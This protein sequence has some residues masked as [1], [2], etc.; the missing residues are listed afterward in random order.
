MKNLLIVLAMLMSTSA[1][2]QSYY[3]YGGNYGDKSYETPKR[4][5]SIGRIDESYINGNSSIARESGRLDRSLE[6]QENRQ[7]YNLINGRNYND[8][9][10]DGRRYR[11]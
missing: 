5:S 7:M 10:Y 9:G 11:Y 4:S 3:D 1:L 6:Y 8:S 2:A